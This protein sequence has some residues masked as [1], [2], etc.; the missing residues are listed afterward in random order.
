M[1]KA[2]L[3]WL[4]LLTIIAI[5]SGCRKNEI[6]IASLDDAKNAKIG[7]MTGSTGE[8]MVIQ[9]FPMRTSKVSMI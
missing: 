5:L 9:G 6:V 8:A 4:I 3:F 2:T 1:K 7:V